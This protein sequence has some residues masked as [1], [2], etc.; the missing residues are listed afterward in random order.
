MSSATP[1]LPPLEAEWLAADGL[2]GFASGTVSGI[3]TRRYHAL[4]LAATQPP[5]GRMV[6]VN[7]LEVWLETAQGRYALSSQ[8]YAPNVTYPDGASHLVA[9]SPFPW[10]QWT[11][12]L[13]DGSEVVQE[14]IVPQGHAATS[15]RWTLRSATS[16]AKKLLVRPLLSGR[17]FHGTHH[18]NSAF[19]FDLWV[20]D[21]MH[22]WQ[23]YPDVPGV[24]VSS[25]G[26]YSHQPCWYRNFLYKQEEQRGLDCEE[27][28]AAPGEFEFELSEGPAELAFAMAGHEIGRAH[29]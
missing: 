2:G 17:D 1:I 16:T 29:V 19:R 14:L 3:R 7:G 24:A 5:A 10:P 9:F 21:G 15:L 13:P 11:Y 12:R 28:L 22:H 18:E 26:R 20:A 23:P 25:N 4:L 6:L 8:L 27:D